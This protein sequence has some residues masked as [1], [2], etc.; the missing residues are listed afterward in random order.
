MH[1]NAELVYLTPAE[2]DLTEIVK[3]HITEVGVQSAREVYALI[4]D[5]IGALAS[6]PL[7]GQTHPDPVLA[8]QG[9]RKLVLNRKYVAVYKVIGNTVFIYRIVNGRADY[10]KL[11]K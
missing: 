2:E 9:F 7:M 3:Y 11:L 10:P 5:K 1:T 4:R 6:F 8:L